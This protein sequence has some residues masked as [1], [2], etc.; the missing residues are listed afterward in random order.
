MQSLTEQATRLLQD[1]RLAEADAPKFREFCE[2]L[3]AY[4]HFEFHRSLETLKK[5]F[6]PFNPDADTIVR[7]QPGPDE[8]VEMQANLVS[9][10]MYGVLGSQGLITM[11]G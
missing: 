6:A 5:N 8:L 1:G 3:S 7:H 9:A 2:I 4:Y 10:F 11:P